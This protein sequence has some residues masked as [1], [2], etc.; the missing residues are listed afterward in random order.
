M[1]ETDASPTSCPKARD[2]A[3]FEVSA[4]LSFRVRL[5]LGFRLGFRKGLGFRVGLG[6]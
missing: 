4:W 3:N 1:A 2:L 5:A 6:C